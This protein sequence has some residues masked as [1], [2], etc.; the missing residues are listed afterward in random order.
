MGILPPLYVWGCYFSTKTPSGEPSLRLL[1]MA[2]LSTIWS[3][4]LTYNFAI[5]GGFSGGEDYRGGIYENGFQACNGK[6]SILS[7]FVRNVRARSANSTRITL[8]KIT[9]EH[10]IIKCENMKSL[11]ETTDDILEYQEH[12]HQKTGTFQHLLIMDSPHRSICNAD[13]S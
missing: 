11:E 9:L 8:S 10:K 13:G 4:R 2:I 1:A 7:S 3:T 6:R 12:Q 5:K